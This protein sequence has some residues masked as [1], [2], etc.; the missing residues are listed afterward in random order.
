MEQKIKNKLK[1][2]LLQ[3]TDG[4]E[5]ETKKARK[6]LNILKLPTNDEIQESLKPENNLNIETVRQKKQNKFKE[7]SDQEKREAELNEVAKNVEYLKL[8][9]ENKKKW[10]FEKLRQI[11]IQK[12]VFSEEKVPENVWPFALNYLSGTKGSS[13]DHLLKNAEAVI[14]SID[15]GLKCIAEDKKTIYNRARELIQI[16]Q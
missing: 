14:K 10:R 12:N 15:E 9:H 4:N 6:N 13:R 2:R 5:I 16:L 3:T 11:S 7:K 1:K 8:W